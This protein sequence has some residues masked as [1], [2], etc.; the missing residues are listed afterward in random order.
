MQHSIYA[1]AEAC[2]L[3]FE[4]AYRVA[5][6][7]RERYGVV[8]FS[9]SCPHSGKNE[10]LHIGTFY[11]DDFVK[12]VEAVQDVEFEG[13]SEAVRHREIAANQARWEAVAQRRR[14]HAL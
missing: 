1:I 13:G 9:G 6:E 10:H 7:N 12:A 3:D 11:A 14:G 4:T 5:N 2:F 8:V